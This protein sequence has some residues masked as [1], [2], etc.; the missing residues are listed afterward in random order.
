MYLDFYSFYIEGY[1]FRL[2]FKRYIAFFGQCYSPLKGT[3]E[4]RVYVPS[5]F[6][7]AHDLEVSPVKTLL[8]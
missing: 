5:Q 2:F 8:S 3:L 6:I 4:R 1:V 7:I